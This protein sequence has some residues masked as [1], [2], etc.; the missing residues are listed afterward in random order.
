MVS[1][2]KLRF[3]SVYTSHIHGRDTETKL[4]QPQNGLF[5][6]WNQPNVLSKDSKAVDAF[7]SRVNAFFKKNIWKEQNTSAPHQKDQLQKN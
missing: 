7:S 2:N 6:H 4:K 1:G 5:D 3:L